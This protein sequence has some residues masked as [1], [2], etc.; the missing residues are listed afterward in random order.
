MCVCMCVR[1]RG[2][3]PEIQSTS[4]NFLSSLEV[5]GAE[6]LLAKDV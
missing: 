1:S 5:G 4:M 6:V 3:E 2:H